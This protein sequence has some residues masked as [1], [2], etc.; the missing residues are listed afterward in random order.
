M[1]LSIYANLTES[2]GKTTEDILLV[3][4]YNG[5]QRG[6]FPRTNF[7]IKIFILKCIKMILFTQKIEN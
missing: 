5:T 3:V 4:S 1:K 7:E 6:V 2:L